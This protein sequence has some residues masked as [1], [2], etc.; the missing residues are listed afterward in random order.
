[1]VFFYSPCYF[2]DLT[3]DAT[4]IFVYGGTFQA[5]SEN[6]PFRNRLTI[7]LHGDRFNTVE[8]PNVGA[9]CLAVMNVSGVTVLS[10]LCVDYC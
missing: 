3:F 1:M 6:E 2:A 8:I 10:F 4:Y 7:T 5:G 9:K